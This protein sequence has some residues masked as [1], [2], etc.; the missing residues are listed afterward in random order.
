M[1]EIPVKPFVLKDVELLIGA[2][3]YAAHVSRVQFTNARQTVTWQG[4]SP[5]ASFSDSSSPTWQAVLDYAQDWETP[6][7]LSR[8]L[9]AN[10]GQT[11]TAKF[12]P[13]K[14]VGLPAF[15]ADVIIAAGP[16]GG[17]GQAVQV[18]SVTLGVVGAP[19]PDYD[20]DPATPNA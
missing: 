7:S 15:T 16:I 5:D 10:D 20:D 8:Y 6:N 17:Q 11:K 12:K 2:D 9:M 1:T 18:G 3:D 14:G 19:V 4:L 13:R